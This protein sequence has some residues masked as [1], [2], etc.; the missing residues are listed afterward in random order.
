MTLAYLI[1][2][3][4]IKTVCKNHLILPVK[5]CVI[6]EELINIYLSMDIVLFIIH[7]PTGVVGKGEHGDS[8]FCY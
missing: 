3:G 6:S 7:T 5:P 8:I 2:E 4:I 1:A